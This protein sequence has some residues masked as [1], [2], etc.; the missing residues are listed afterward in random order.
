MDYPADADLSHLETA[1][2]GAC[3]TEPELNADPDSC[4][5]RIRG[6]MEEMDSVDNI[7]FYAEQS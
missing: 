2:E 4:L 1:A 6:A 3:V 7:D 5:A